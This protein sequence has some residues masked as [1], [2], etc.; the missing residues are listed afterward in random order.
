MIHTEGKDKAITK[1]IAASTLYWKLIPYTMKPDARV[2]A[3][4]VRLAPRRLGWRIVIE[5]STLIL[6]Q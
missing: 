3:N 2:N 4:A 5:E 1:P 6:L